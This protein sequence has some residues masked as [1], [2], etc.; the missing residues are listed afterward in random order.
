MHISGSAG[1]GKTVALMHRA[2][3]LAKKLEDTR[4]KVLLTTFTT[5]LSIML[6]NQVQKLDPK[7]SG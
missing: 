3:H 7:G 4:D 2:V 5:N 6:K 1:T